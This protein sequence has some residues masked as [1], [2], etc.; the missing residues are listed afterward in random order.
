M[1]LICGALAENIDDSST[2]LSCR[3]I[4]RSLALC[5][6]KVESRPTKKSPPFQP[7]TTADAFD[8]HWLCED[9]R[10]DFFMRRIVLST[11]VRHDGDCTSI[12]LSLVSA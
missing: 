1:L 4:W 11:F 9:I 10:T 12:D 7:V 6:E 3:Q 5:G 2:N 8:V